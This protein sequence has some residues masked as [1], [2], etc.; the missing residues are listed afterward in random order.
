[1]VHL[2][3]LYK[4]HQVHLDQVQSRAF[5]SPALLFVLQLWE[6]YSVSGVSHTLEGLVEGEQVQLV[7]SLKVYLL[8]LKQL[9]SKTLS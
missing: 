2:F 8:T 3:N 7:S 6:Q 9:D 4:A 1:M 5:Y